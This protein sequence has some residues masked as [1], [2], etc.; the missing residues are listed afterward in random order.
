MFS[1]VPK[2]QSFGDR[3]VFRGNKRSLPNVRKS[4]L[5]LECSFSIKL[6]AVQSNHTIL[7]HSKFAD[8][9]LN[10]QDLSK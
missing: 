10:M 7:S 2:Y 6:Y 9:C 8:T 1:S 5:S 3:K 4:G